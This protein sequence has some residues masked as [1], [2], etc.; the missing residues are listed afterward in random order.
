MISVV[1]KA[2]DSINYSILVHKLASYHCSS[3]TVNWFKSYLHGRTQSVDINGFTY[4]LEA[5]Y[6]LWCASGLYTGAVTIF[7]LFVNDLHLHISECD[8]NL[9]A[10]D[11]NLYS[12]GK[13]VDE[14]QT[15]L[16]NDMCTLYQWCKTNR[17]GINFTKTAC[18]LISTSQKRSHVHSCG[19]DV[20]V[21]D[22]QISVC[23]S[24]K[25]LGIN[26]YKQNTRLDCTDQ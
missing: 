23:K 14:I 15:Q 2:F 5:R 6:Y 4:V 7:I 26:C 11:T 12:V 24:H 16:S 22:V 3:M 8:L 20:N 13:T 10:D 19:L 1:C 18:T 25:V 9:Y 17:L 21:L